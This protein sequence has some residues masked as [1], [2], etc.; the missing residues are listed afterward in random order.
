MFLANERTRRHLAVGLGFCLVL[1]SVGP[2]VAIACE[3][4]GEE[5]PEKVLTV[6]KAG[7]PEAVVGDT[8]KVALE[9]VTKSQFITTE[10]EI[11]CGKSEMV[12]KI[13]SNP[14]KGT[15][16]AEVKIESL[17]FGECTTNIP[18]VTVKAV[19]MEALPLLA[20]TAGT[21]EFEMQQPG[22]KD[23][24]LEFT[25]ESGGEERICVY[26][27]IALKAKYR[28]NN[29]GELEIGKEFSEGYF[30]RMNCNLPYPTWKAKYRPLKDETGGRAG[31]QIFIN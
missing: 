13:E 26:R 1:A 11:A 23:V 14:R 20:K 17:P 27:V 19:T 28:N 21:T 5:K 31:K 15:G 18:G 6:E 22:N 2:S 8:V 24:G 7:G 29:E 30:N 25:Y 12:G 4:G 3:G 16:E 10:G 9:P